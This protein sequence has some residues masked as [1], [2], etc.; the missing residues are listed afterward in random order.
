MW[1]EMKRTDTHIHTARATYNHRALTHTQLHTD[2]SAKVAQKRGF[3]R[4]LRQRQ[5]R[6]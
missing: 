3:L 4:R 6:L 1:Y 5:R 2:T